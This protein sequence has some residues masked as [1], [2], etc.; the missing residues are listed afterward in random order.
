MMSTVLVFSFR[1]PNR[2][3]NV[4]QYINTDWPEYDVTS[5]K[6]LNLTPNSPIG[7]VGERFANREMEFWT[8]LIPSLVQAAKL[9]QRT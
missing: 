3:E 5:Q 9:A 6:F 2:P 1:D 8:T 7:S 4:Q